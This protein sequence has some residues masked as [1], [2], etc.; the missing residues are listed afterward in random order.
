LRAWGDEAFG[1]AFEA[2]PE[3]IPGAIYVFRI[4]NA[5]FLVPGRGG[6]V[7]PDALLSLARTVSGRVR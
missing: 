4:R 3:G 5:V 7:D 1:F 6:T 2:G